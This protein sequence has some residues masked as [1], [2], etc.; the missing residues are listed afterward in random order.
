MRRAGLPLGALVL[1]LLA[2]CSVGDQSAAASA[3]V[4]RFH[5]GTFITGFYKTTFSEGE[6][7]EK[8]VFRVRD[9]SAALAGYFINSNDLI[10]R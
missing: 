5:G 10:V 9:K 6:A 3:G 1:S 4:V 8:F 2:S 7:Q